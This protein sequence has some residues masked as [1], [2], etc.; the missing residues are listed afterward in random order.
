MSERVSVVIPAHDE[1]SVIGRLLRRL[2]DS[3]L[4]GRLEI[5]VVA[6][7]CT[8]DTAAIAAGIP[9]VRVVVIPQTSKIAALNAGDAAATEFPRAYVDADITVTGDAILAVADALSDEGPLVGAPRLV[10]DVD[11]ASLLVRWFYR[12]WALT[13]YR[14]AGAVGSGVYVVSAA[15]RQRFGRFPEVIADDLYVRNHFTAAERVVVDE[16]TFTLRAPRTF[17]SFLRRQTRITAGNQQLAERFPALTRDEASS[18]RALL[19]RV[20]RRPSLWLPAI[21]Y[22]TSAVISRLGASRMRGRWAAQPWNRD[23]TSR[24]PPGTAISRESSA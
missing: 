12:V 1:A 11:A 14:V 6:N 22:V 19:G 17:R 15:G 18:T 13:D 7:G 24:L 23:E 20:A 16:Y 8:D 5:V 3:D 21:T 10:V 4:E 2:V 9:P